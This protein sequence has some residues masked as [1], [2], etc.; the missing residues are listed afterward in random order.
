LPFELRQFHS[1]N[2][3]EFLN[4][5]L[6]RYFQEGRIPV[7]MTRSR[8]RHKNDNAHVE[9]KNFT[10][11]R[12]LLGYSRLDEPSRVAACNQ[13]YSAWS[14]FNNYFSSNLKLIGKEKIGSRYRKKY[15]RPKTPYR[16]LMESADVSEAS[17]MHMT[18]VFLH[19]DPFKLK[20]LIDYQQQQILAT[21]R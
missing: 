10:H 4:R 21:V 3:G 13:L 7:P 19:L 6:I 16:R 8:P 17:K 9:Q 15:D 14:L 11:V 20:R 12:L 1:D 18:E 2:G 5:H